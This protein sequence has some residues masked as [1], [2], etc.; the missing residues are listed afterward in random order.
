MSEC[1]GANT[2][3]FVR[4][5][6][7]RVSYFTVF[8][9]STFFV[10]AHNKSKR[11]PPQAAFLAGVSVC[12]LSSL[13]PS[14]YIL[15]LTIYPTR[16]VCERLSHLGSSRA[17]RAGSS[18]TEAL[19]LEERQDDG[20]PREPADAAAAVGAAQVAC[21][22]GRRGVPKGVDAGRSVDA[23]IEAEKREVLDV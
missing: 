21:L 13:L 20:V 3:S 11:P 14:L 17:I 1:Q 22:S 6:R 15:P 9:K 19:Q 2:P 8:I 4:C 10:T 23:Q 12:G 16:V 5:H 18:P 7:T